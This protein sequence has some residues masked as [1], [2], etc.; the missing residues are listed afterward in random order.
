VG[1]ESVYVV[2]HIALTIEADVIVPDE[3]LS[4]Q[5]TLFRFFEIVA[6]TART[7]AD[8]A[9][10]GPYPVIQLVMIFHVDLGNGFAVAEELIAVITKHHPFFTPRKASA[11]ARLT[12]IV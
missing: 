2:R 3:R 8:I 4:A 1:S 9:V 10:F 7:G 5:L 12:R 11:F 6:A